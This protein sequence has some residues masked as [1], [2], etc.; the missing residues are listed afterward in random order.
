MMHRCIQ[1]LLCL[2][3]TGS[4]F[5]QDTLV[6]KWDIVR[7]VDYALKNNISVRQ[8]DLQSRFSELTYGQS[9]AAQIPTLNAGGSAG[10]SFGRPEDPSTGIRETINLFTTQ[11]Q[12][13]SR[14]NLFNWFS[15]K[16]TIESN[17]LNWEADKEQVNKLKNDIALNVAA[18][19]LQILL[20]KEQLRIAQ[21]QVTQTET[22]LDLTRKRVE[23]GALPELN[24]AELEAQ[25]ARDNSNEIAAETSVLQY[26]LQMK[27]LLNL[28]A[29]KP[30]DIVTPSVDKIPVDPI[31]ELLPEKVYALALANMP[32][33][34]VNSLRIQSAHKAIAAAKGTLYPTISAYGS[35]GTLS[36]NRGAPQFI[37]SG[38]E[39]SL[40]YVTV[41]STDYIV[42]TPNTTKTGEIKVP[43]GRQYRTNF[44]QGIGISLSVP[45][46][47][48]RTARTSWDRSKLN[49]KS[50]EL[51]REQ[52]DMQLK[53][54]IYTAYNDAVKALELFNANK[55]S[56]ETAKK[57]YDY[58][59]KRYEANLL[60][61]YDLVNSRNS[62]RNALIQSAYAQFDYLFKMKVLEF[63]KGQGIRLQ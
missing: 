54:D 47:N 43:L 25:L 30:F 13:Q 1:L 27:A 22:Q 24:A 12:V 33:Q 20:G 4:L 57:A 56:E 48:G 45:I 58:A 38:F 34:K 5:A 42:Y 60:S 19:Y 9:K 53:Q 35:L 6:E 36:T 17:R 29:A 11:L 10:F 52:S 50:L 63:Y 62:Y 16:N 41:G 61:I 40:A 55:K 2:V 15:Q 28:D 59:Q 8:T 49:L 14:V 46:F 44:E 31:A 23:A 21:L 7:C 37:V 39:P 26:I 32:Q 3:S 18:A 51:Q